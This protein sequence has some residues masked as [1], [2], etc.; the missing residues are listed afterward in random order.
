LFIYV[1]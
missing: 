1:N